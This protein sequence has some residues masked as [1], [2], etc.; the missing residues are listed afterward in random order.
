MEGYIQTGIG[1]AFSVVF[2]LIGYRQTIGARNERIRSANRSIYKAL[3][4]RLVLEDYLPKVEEINRL[5]EGKAHEHRVTVGDLYPNEQVLNQVFAEVFDNDFIAPE[6]RLEI[7]ARISQ[8]F[9]ELDSR[10][11][12]PGDP[13]AFSAGYQRQK[14]LATVLSILASLSGALVSLLLVLKRD[15]GDEGPTDFEQFIP[16]GLVFV[17]SMVAVLAISIVKKAREAPN[18]AERATTQE[19]AQLSQ[20]VSGILR[21]LGLEYEVVRDLGGRF[22]P[23][24]LVQM[25][26]G[27]PWRL[28]RCHG[29][30][31]HPLRFSPER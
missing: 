30:R 27:R 9:D 23:D 4:R 10:R 11:K 15:S 29:E 2:F 12:S 31:R 21:L 22:R 25:G 24:F 28:R 5:I 26:G 1:V 20:E 19:R 14:R 13:L 8:A 18:D 7:E 17:V 6:K 16:I 3:L